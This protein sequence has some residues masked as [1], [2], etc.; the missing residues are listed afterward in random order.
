MTTTRTHFTFRV[1]ILPPRP[2]K[3]PP[4]RPPRPP[5][6]PPPHSGKRHTASEAGPRRAFR[7]RPPLPI[8]LALFLPGR[9]L[10]LLAEIW[11]ERRHHL[12]KRQVEI[13]KH[14]CQDQSQ[15]KIRYLLYPAQKKDGQS[16]YCV[17]RPPFSL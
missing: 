16:K 11:S 1:A 8:T 17:D 3:P 6:P 9:I 15:T 5:P 14:F 2:P 13:S 7:S 10:G 4:P 12:L